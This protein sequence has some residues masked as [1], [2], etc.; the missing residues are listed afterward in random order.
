V[1]GGDGGDTDDW[2]RAHLKARTVF[3]RES[4]R[5]TGMSRWRFEVTDGIGHEFANEYFPML[6]D[7]AGGVGAE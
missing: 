4:A 6:R 5:W 1:G 7:W 3:L 2:W